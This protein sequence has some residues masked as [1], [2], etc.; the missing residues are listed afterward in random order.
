M[1]YKPVWHVIRETFVWI[2]SLS[3]WFRTVSTGRQFVGPW[4]R[5]PTTFWKGQRQR[6][7]SLR[8]WKSMLDCFVPLHGILWWMRCDVHEKSPLCLGDWRVPSTLLCV[9]SSFLVAQL[10]CGKC[11]LSCNPLRNGENC[12]LDMLTMWTTCLRHFSRDKPIRL[13]QEWMHSPTLASHRNG[14]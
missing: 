4:F 9:V 3:P 13:Q 6:W 5:I 12:R 7:L 10:L 2:S 14:K 1:L 11:I 8:N